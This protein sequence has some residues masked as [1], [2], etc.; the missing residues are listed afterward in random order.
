MKD[1]E[2]L[3]ILLRTGRV[4]KNAVEL[5]EDILAK[6]PLPTLAH[7]TLGQIQ[8]IEGIDQGKACTILAAFELSHRARICEDKSENTINVPA[9]AL[10][11]LSDIRA[12]K[13]EYFVALYLN[14]R[15]HYIHKEI[16]SIG[17]INASIVHPRE[18]FEP[19][20]RVSA[21]ALIIAHNHPSHDPNPSDQDIKITKKLI[22]AGKILDMEILDHLIITERSFISLK[23]K[24]FI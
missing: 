5:A 10:V 1:K 11:Y 13:K 7:S 21:C 2:I 20:I 3:A 12:R 9:D 24:G 23:E 22:E 18:V 14:A 15:N 4:G 8:D 16:I 6:Y 19:A 17:T